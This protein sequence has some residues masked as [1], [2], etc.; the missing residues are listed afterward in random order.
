MANTVRVIHRVMQHRRNNT[1]STIRRS[2]HHTTAKSILLINRQS[3][4]VHPV[5]SKLRRLRRVLHHQI[6]MPSTRTATHLQRTRQITHTRQR[7]TNTFLHHTVDMQ[8]AIADLLLRT[9]RTLIR[10]LQLRN[11]QASIIRHL[12]QLSRRTKRIRRVHQRRATGRLL[13]TLNNETATNRIIGTLQQQLL[14]FKRRNLHTVRMARKN[15][16]RAQSHIQLTVLHHRA[17]HLL[18]LT[19]GSTHAIRRRRVTSQRQSTIHAIA[20]HHRLRIS[21]IDRLRHKTAQP[22]QRRAHRAVTGTRSR[23]RTIQ[24]HVHTRHTIQQTLINQLRH[25]TVRS[26]HR[27]DR[28]RARRTHTNAEHL[29]NTDVIRQSLC[30]LLHA[31]GRTLVNSH[32]LSFK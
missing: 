28:M 32:V 13:I 8:D 31:A 21:N 1:R 18:I 14:T 4:Q 7:R 22:L 30:L 6:T 27:T 12:Q 20:L 25:K 19:T 26:T 2:S 23:Q 5:N 29:K 24:I 16:Q 11:R 3:N 17:V 9:Q 10:H 15:R